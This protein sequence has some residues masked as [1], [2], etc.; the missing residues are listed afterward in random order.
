MHS[1]INSVVRPTMVNW[2]SFGIWF[3]HPRVLG[4]RAGCNKIPV[5]PHSVAGCECEREMSL[6][7]FCTK[8]QEGHKSEGRINSINQS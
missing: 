2:E 4:S 1:S 3:V 7:A 5:G 6:L 8:E